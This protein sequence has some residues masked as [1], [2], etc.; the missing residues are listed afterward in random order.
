MEFSHIKCAPYPEISTAEDS[1]RTGRDCLQMETK[2]K[3]KKKREFLVFTSEICKRKPSKGRECLVPALLS[4]TNPTTSHPACLTVCIDRNFI[5]GVLASR[6]VHTQHPKWTQAPVSVDKLLP[7][8]CLEAQ[9]AE[10]GQAV[11]GNLCTRAAAPA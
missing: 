5:T 8:M 3:K 4:V 9:G 7:S 6:A 2:E 11:P 10:G 1:T